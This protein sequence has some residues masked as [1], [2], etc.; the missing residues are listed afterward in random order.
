MRIR[1]IKV[2]AVLTGSCLKPE[3]LIPETRGLPVPKHRAMPRAGNNLAQLSEYRA[4]SCVSHQSDVAVI[5]MNL[6][7]LLG[8]SRVVMRNV[9]G[10]TNWLEVLMLL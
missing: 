6:D 4:S 1:F 2:C 8:K 3:L 7:R 10:V 9:F 5:Y